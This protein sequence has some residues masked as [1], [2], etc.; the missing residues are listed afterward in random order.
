M[1]EPESPQLRNSLPRFEITIWPVNVFVKLVP[2]H[3]FS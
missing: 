3:S 1:S 2:A